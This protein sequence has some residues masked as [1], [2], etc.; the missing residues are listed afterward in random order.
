MKPKKLK[1]VKDRNIMD[2]PD[3]SYLNV[4]FTGR[5]LINIVELL[6][7]S[8]SAFQALAEESVKLNDF[9][10]VGNYV[11][12]QKLS[13]ELYAKLVAFA[14]IGEPTAPLQ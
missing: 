5:E 14:K 11:S 9:T 7:F 2:V 4:P 1:E 12:C 13:E 3:G 10:A 8:K 6:A